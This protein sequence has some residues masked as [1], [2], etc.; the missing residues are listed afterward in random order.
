MQLIPGTHKKR[1]YKSSE[2]Q[3]MDLNKYVLD[4]AIDPKK[5]DESKAIWMQ[6][7]VI[8]EEAFEAAKNAG[9][10]V[11]MNDCILRRHHEMERDL[12]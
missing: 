6:D 3:K 5:L 11:V 2:M 8:N 9:F 10:L 12:Q 4:L 1:L 7:G